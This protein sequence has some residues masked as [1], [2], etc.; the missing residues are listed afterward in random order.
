MNSMINELWQEERLAGLADVEGVCDN[1]LSQMV[2]AGFS[3]KDHF[4][5]RVSL[6]EA[7]INAFKHGHGGIPGKTVRIRYTVTVQRA[8]VEIKDQGPGFDPDKVPDPLTASNIGRSSGRGL[9]LIRHYM[10][11]VRFNYRGNCIT[12]CKEKRANG[13]LCSTAAQIFS[14]SRE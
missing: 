7:L 5:M 6:E 13:S 8:I 10:T 1:I 4:G 2:A 3:R 11:A 12:M 14:E 9:F